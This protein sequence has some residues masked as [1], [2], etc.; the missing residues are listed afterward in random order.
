MLSALKG[1]FFKTPEDLSKLTLDELK[2]KNKERRDKLLQKYSEDLDMDQENVGSGLVGLGNLGNTCYMNSALQCL[3]KTEELT[4]YLLSMNWYSELNCV[5][6]M[7]TE[8]ELFVEYAYLVKTMF[9]K[10]AGSSF[11]PSNFKS[12]LSDRNSQ[13]AEV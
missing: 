13:V 11:R 6:F 7:G 3:T 2:K 9:E 1:Y 5:S 10:K 4:Q 8:G 12:K